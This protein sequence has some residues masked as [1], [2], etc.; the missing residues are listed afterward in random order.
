MKIIVNI[1]KKIK[2]THVIKKKLICGIVLLP[3]EVKS[4]KKNGFQINSSY[5]QIKNNEIYL[6]NSYIN[7]NNYNKELE[8]RKRK[9]LLKKKEINEINKEIKNKF[10][11]IPTKIFW[12][13]IFLKLE[14]S[15]CLKIK[16]KDIRKNELENLKKKEIKQ[17]I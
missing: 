2:K 16:K 1:E 3:W 6:I 8:K 10:I 15:L 9:L 5:A 17:I 11:V 13:K 4:I 14:I 7:N 12:K